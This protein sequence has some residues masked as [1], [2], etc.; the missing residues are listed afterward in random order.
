MTKSLPPTA[1]KVIRFGSLTSLAMALFAGSLASAGE[2][3]YSGKSGYSGKN[4][5]PGSAIAERARA[6][7]Q[8]RLREAE[9]LRAEGIRAYNDGNC[10]LAFAKLG[11]ALE[12]LP[13]APATDKLRSKIVD[14]YSKAGICYAQELADAYRYAEAKSVLNDV[15]AADPDNEKAKKLLSDLDDPERYPVAA[16]PQLGEDIAEV[17]RLLNLAYSHYELGEYDKAEDVYNSVLRI[18]PYNKAARNGLERVET[19]RSDY[20]Q[21][22]YDH[23]RAR[24]LRMVDEGWETSVPLATDLGL[25]VDPGL[26]PASDG[27]AYI[28]TKL[29]EINLPVVSFIDTPVDE[30]LEF[31]RLQSIEN[32]TLESD[33]TKKGVNFI[34]QLPSGGGAA[35]APSGGGDDLGL[36]GLGGDFGG[37]GGGGNVGNSI[38]T[39]SINQL[40]NVPLIEALRYV[41]EGAGLKYKIEP[42]AVVVVPQSDTS[43][44]MYQ[45][46]FRVPPD[47]LE[48]IAA[49]G[50]GGSSGGAFDP[51]AAGGGDSGGG[52]EAR[53]NAREALSQAGVPFGDGSSAV[54]NPGNSTLTVRNTQAAMELIEILVDSVRLKAPNQVAISSKFIEVQQEDEN[55]LGFNWLLGSFGVGPFG[56][57]ED[58][59]QISGGTEGTGVPL[60]NG[61]QS[62]NFPTVTGLGQTNPVTSGLRSGDFGI[63]RGALDAVLG[64]SASAAAIQTAAPGLLSLTGI[65][66][67]PQF[68]LVIRAL[69]QK[70]G[71]D[72]MSAPSVTT[73]SGQR[74]K[75]EVIRE[76][77]YPSEYDPPELPDR[78]GLTGT[79]TLVTD[80]ITGLVTGNAS[81]SG[82]P[83][84]P[85]NPTA[86]VNKN[87]GVTL[88]VDPVVGGNGYT[89]D[90][91]LAPEVIEFDGFINYGTPISA[92][93]TDVFGNSTSTIITENRILQPVFGTR[94][95]QT[96]V[97]V[98]D[99]QTVGIG[100]LIREDVQK[101]EDKVPV[102]GDVPILGRLFRSRVENKLRRNLMIFVTAELI[103]PS[104]R[105]VNETSAAV[106][107]GLNGLGGPAASA[108]LPSVPT[109][110]F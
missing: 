75:I 52:I 100:G 44:D 10:E 103:D 26:D 92:P 73:K 63:S 22:A 14:E 88:E 70:K 47:F 85:A 27:R 32:D 69:D 97:T 76:F 55:E 11:E 94:R 71:T 8:A 43:G 78:V 20:Y 65:F 108:L 61:D 95:V 66:T 99:G 25:G 3:D 59:I 62:S 41:C 110:G 49:S 84:T 105:P 39:V 87:I 80:P 21:S 54:F 77:W 6:Q 29:K 48:S 37:L 31:L 13:Q 64:G 68:Q 91:N 53:P 36:G 72:F 56:V 23:T 5:S 90:L 12:V 93:G 96:S 79:E 18:D 101:V 58:G 104:G 42:F 50:G 89:I 67:D 1:F 35:A 82:F 46:V 4:G 7:K 109:S 102:L 83:V 81:S 60:L 15:L 9:E 51:F 33:P 17:N 74:A 106:D 30:A 34:L 28:E 98:W 107:S 2:S 16:T 45:K 38:P 24:M 86:F 57:A 19:I 40:R